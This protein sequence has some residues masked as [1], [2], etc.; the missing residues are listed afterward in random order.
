MTTP[1]CLVI[2]PT[3]NHFDQFLRDKALEHPNEIKKMRHF[4]IIGG[5]SY[6]YIRDQDSL[7]GFHGVKVEV[8]GLPPGDAHEWRWL[9]ENARRG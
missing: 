8:L 4:T 6:Q 9:I 2:A 1:I 3:R 5:L 7:R